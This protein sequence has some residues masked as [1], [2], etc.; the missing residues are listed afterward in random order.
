MSPQL[1]LVLMVAL[2]TASV[3]GLFTRKPIYYLAV[4]WLVGVCAMLIGQV[5]GRAA[6]ITRFTVGEVEL[7]VGLVVNVAML[8]GM[9]WLGL[10][11]TV[12]G[13]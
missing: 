1:L 13:R 11:Y 2:L 4:Y 9:H 5:L 8:I 12:R 6:G 7:G 3:T 10:W